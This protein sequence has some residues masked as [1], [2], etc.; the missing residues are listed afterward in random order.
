MA[1][2]VRNSW[3]DAEGDVVVAKRADRRSL[4]FLLGAYTAVITFIFLQSLA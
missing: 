1:M 3:V 2:I 4:I